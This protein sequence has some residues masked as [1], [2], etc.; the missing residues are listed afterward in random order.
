M[1][2]GGKVGALMEGGRRGCHDGRGE[3]YGGEEKDRSLF[4]VRNHAHER[5]CAQKD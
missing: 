4:I 3:G 2:S 5:P 1:G